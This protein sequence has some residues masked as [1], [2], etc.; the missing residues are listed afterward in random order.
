MFKYHRILRL[1]VKNASADRVLIFSEF[2]TAG[3]TAENVREEKTVLTC[4]RCSSG[5]DA[6][7]DTLVG[8]YSSDSSQK[9]DVCPVCLTRKVTVAIL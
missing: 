9:Y 2:Q 1:K 5:A 3:A 8:R 4:G 6:K 7:C